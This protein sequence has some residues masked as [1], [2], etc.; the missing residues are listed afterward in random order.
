MSKAKSTLYLSVARFFGLAISLISLP[1]YFGWLGKE[2]WG[3][4]LTLTLLNRFVSLV[5][6][7]LIDGSTREMTSGFAAGDAARAHRAWRTTLVVGATVGLATALIYWGLSLLIKIAEI[8]NV[9]GYSGLF[10]LAGVAFGLNY[11]A[12]AYGSVFSSQRRF[13][14]VAITNAVMNLVGAISSL[15][16]VY[17]FRTPHVFFVGT[18][19]GSLATLGIAWQMQRKAD[20]PAV[21]G[22]VDREC[23]DA[24]LKYGAKMYVNKIAA[25]FANV[26]DKL[27]TV[28]ALGT[29]KLANYS[30]GGRIPETGFELLPIN[31]VVLQD[32]IHAKEQGAQAFA[33]A[34]ERSTRIALAVGCCLILVP[35]SLGE[36]VLRL[37]LKDQFVAEMAPVMLF[38]GFYR[39]LEVYY[40]SIGSALYGFGVPQRAAPYTIYNAVATAAL[41]YP[42]AKSY[43][44][45]GLALVNVGIH[46]LQFLPLTYQASKWLAPG[47]QLRQHFSKLAGI[48]AVTLALA[49]AGWYT[50]QS[51]LLR[52][53]P[54]LVLLLAPIWSGLA[55][56]IVF[57][58]GFAEKPHFFGKL[59]SK[60]GL[61][62]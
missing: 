41:A 55:V 57:K 58:A 52:T 48:L 45:V 16:L 37:W 50:S 5:D 13:G 32:F 31:Q 39:A 36:P 53:S 33:Q 56:M 11:L 47:I 61:G 26:A 6:F 1:L 19:I 29:E 27:L 10:L 22:W 7:S 62:G 8:Q 17:F 49:A 21:E 4:I 2:V 40:G 43:G 51:D 30:A 34:F 15:T 54:W 42:V 44:I 24:S 60:L 18:I 12:T 20:R 3:A 14:E 28:P 9:G 25:A 46:S 59:K 23:L 35:C 38:I